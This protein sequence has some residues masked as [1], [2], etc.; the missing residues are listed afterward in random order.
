MGNMSCDQEERG[1]TDYQAEPVHRVALNEI[2]DVAVL[3][4]L[5]NHKALSGEAVDI[6]CDESQDIRM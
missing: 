4:E 3:H 2:E 5:G 6:G 1:R